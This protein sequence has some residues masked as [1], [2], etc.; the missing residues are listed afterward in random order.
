MIKFNLV[1]T[2]LFKFRGNDINYCLPQPKTIGVLG[3]V[4]VKL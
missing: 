1:C 3:W 4:K 2:K